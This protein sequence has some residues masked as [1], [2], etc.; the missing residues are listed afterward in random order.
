[1]ARPK[2]DMHSIAHGASPPVL[3]EITQALTEFGRSPNF[4]VHCTVLA[5]FLC[6]GLGSAF[7][8]WGISQNLKIVVWAGLSW[9]M[10]SFALWAGL[11]VVTLWMLGRLVMDFVRAM[12]RENP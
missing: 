1:M 8:S 4:L 7:L 12:R 6:L 9:L 10:L 5:A 11:G 2:I 3:T